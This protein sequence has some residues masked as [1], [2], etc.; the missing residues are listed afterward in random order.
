MDG[1]KP[2]ALK[3]KSFAEIKEL[4]NKSM[5]RINN[6]VDFITEL[7]EK[8]TKKD[9]AEIAQESS[10]KRVEDELN[11]ERS[12]KHKI[13]DENESAELKRCLEIVP[14][15]GDEVTIDDT[16]LSSKSLTIFDYKI[17][18]EGRKSFFQIT[19]ADGEDCW[20]IKAKDF[21]DVVKDY[22]CCWSSWKRLS[23]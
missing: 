12:K 8:S 22:Y 18:K 21:I 10:L 15:D 2:R 13:K 14:D 17:Y 7:V 9:K 3:N 23:G 20:D 5:A 1:W 4:F 16:H 11:Q 19:R 6:F